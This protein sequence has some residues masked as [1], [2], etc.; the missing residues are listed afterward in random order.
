MD[1]QLDST[2]RRL[3]REVTH[4][5][6]RDIESSVLARIANAEEARAGRWRAGRWRVD[7]L[8]FLGALV[9]GLAGAAAI[10]AP[11][12]A[13]TVASLG[14]VSRLAPSALLEHGR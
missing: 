14:E 4:P 7:A 13:S 2:I 6:L 10:T 12:T 8:S 9:M 5:R 1:N 3:S 11:T